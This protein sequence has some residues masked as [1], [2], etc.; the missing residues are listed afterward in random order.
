MN[1]G[2]VGAFFL[3]AHTTSTLL[4][5]GKAQ[6][7]RNLALGYN[8]AAHLEAYFKE[9]REGMKPG[10]LA[11]FPAGEADLGTILVKTI[12]NPGS[13]GKVVTP[14]MVGTI[15]NARSPSTSF[16]VVVLG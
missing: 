14:E 3:Q 10:M 2:T 13:P 5:G 9:L 6:D 15:V 8:A 16:K 12:T 7:P 11:A 1:V 4:K